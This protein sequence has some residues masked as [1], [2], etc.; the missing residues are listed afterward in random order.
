MV[1]VSVR[2]RGTQCGIQYVPHPQG[3]FIYQDSI[4]IVVPDDSGLLLL[5]TLG[6]FHGIDKDVDEFL[7]SW[8]VMA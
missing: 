2:I 8:L 5:S 3:R 7:P 6:G 1:G 4:W